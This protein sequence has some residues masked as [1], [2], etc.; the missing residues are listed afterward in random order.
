MSDPRWAE[1]FARLDAL[2]K[3]VFADDIVKDVKPKAKK[4]VVQA[5]DESVTDKAFEAFEAPK[6]VAKK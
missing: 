6:E 4:A 3:R 5:E 2:E 1:V